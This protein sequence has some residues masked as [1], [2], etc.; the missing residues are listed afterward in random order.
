MSSS[1]CCFL[2]CLQISQEA[3]QV[4]WYSHLFQN[5]PQFIVIHTVKGFGVVHRA[6]IDVFLEISCFFDDPVDADKLTCEQRPE[7]SGV[8]FFLTA[9]VQEGE[10]A[11]KSQGEACRACSNPTWLVT[12]PDNLFYSKTYPHPV[13]I[14]LSSF[15][16]PDRFIIPCL[17]RLFSV[18]CES[19]RLRLSGS[20]IAARAFSSV[21]HTAGA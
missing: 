7:R 21:G 15:I 5:C 12:L 17:L 1:I 9:A 18:L 11:Q 13:F 14:P 3:G 16:P 20:P 8:F 2:T 4:V 19:R 10:T 6:E